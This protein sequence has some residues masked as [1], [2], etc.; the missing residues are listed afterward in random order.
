VDQA[1]A[2]A[3]EAATLFVGL[4]RRISGGLAISGGPPPLMR[5]LHRFVNSMTSIV[6]SCHGTSVDSS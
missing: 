5:A 4:T 3:G 2:T 6:I 1:C